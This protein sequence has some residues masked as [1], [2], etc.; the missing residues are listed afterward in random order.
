MDK[1]TRQSLKGPDAFLKYIDLILNQIK[2]HRAIV[3]TIIV[4]LILVG[5]GTTA[6]SLYNEKLEARA[7]SDL[8]LAQKKY[9][10]IKDQFEQS[11]AQSLA[12]KKDKNAKVTATVL[13]TGDIEKDYGSALR[14]YQDVL[15]K[16]PGT[17]SSVQAALEQSQ[18]YADYQNFDKA[19]ELLKGAEK[20]S[21]RSTLLEGLV[22]LARGALHE[23][24]GECPQSI[25]LYDHLLASKD[26]SYLHAETYYRKA[27]CQ[28]SMQ[29]VSA[30]KDLYKKIIQDY[31]D[32]KTGRAA[33]RSLRNLE[34]QGS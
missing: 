22:S 5:V 10:T 4:A 27:L 18:I 8:F 6:Y 3:L 20:T 7:Q 9:D 11:K 31:P 15:Q 19:L 16:H 32:S 33:R 14:A 26:F 30:A 28:E 17:K 12:Q 25:E 24:K 13:P 34:S 29:N 1:I 23:K 2:K 21:K